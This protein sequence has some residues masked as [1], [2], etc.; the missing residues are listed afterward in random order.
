MFAH[1]Y[2]SSAYF[3]PEYFA[4]VAVT[5]PKAVAP[6]GGHSAYAPRYDREIELQIARED[7][8]IIEMLSILASRRLI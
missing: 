8:E 3:R 7:E 2:F 1:N 6:G 5:T 4:P